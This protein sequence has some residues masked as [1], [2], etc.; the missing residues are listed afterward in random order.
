MAVA[1]LTQ[2]LSI[3]ITANHVL[4]YRGIFDAYGHISVRNPNN[5]STFFL[6]RDLAPAL[7]SSPHDIVEYRID[8]ASAVFPNAP[9]GV[10]ERFIH[11][12]VLKRY[13]A[14]NSVI[15]SHARAV[16]PYGITKVPLL[17]VTQSGV[18][19]GSK[20]CESAPVFEIADYFL[21]WDAHVL[22]VRNARFGAALASLFSSNDTR[23]NTGASPTNNV[24][25]MRG[26]GMAVVGQD[27]V[28]AVFR[29]ISTPNVADI[30]RDA[31]ILAALGGTDG[32]PGRSG[33]I[34]YLTEQEKRDI[35]AQGT[36][37]H[38]RGWEL[39]VREV[40]AAAT[41]DLYRNCLGSPL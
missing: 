30:Q 37:H 35:A 22:L 39:W 23:T 18:V 13:P 41:K 6:S 34:R 2:L 1:N 38:R 5:A 24:V 11:S 7:V 25:L 8:D 32:Q 21:P 12:E 40:E 16:I 4:H 19:L 14:V 29:A 15:H 3:L 36:S 33:R 17:P 10:T 27:I 31:L 26:H 28:T 20:L 9:A